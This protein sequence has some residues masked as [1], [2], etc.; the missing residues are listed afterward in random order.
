M[1]KDD[2]AKHVDIPKMKLSYLLRG[3]ALS[4]IVSGYIIGPLLVIGGGT[5][6]LYKNDYVSK[7]V[8]V[9]A[10][11][12]AFAASNA[13][14]IL[15]SKKMIEKFNKKTGI[16]DPTREQVAQWKKNRPS[17]YKFDDEEKD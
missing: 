13:L 5:W 6:W 16:K 7:F 2:N 12:I 1:K 14:I 4:A 17:S 15:Q 3:F 8:V 11:I 9:I 10:V